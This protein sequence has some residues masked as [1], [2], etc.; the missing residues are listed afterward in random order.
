VKLKEREPDE[1]EDNKSVTASD[2]EGPA[3][4]EDGES[5]LEEDAAT[6]SKRC[7]Q[8]CGYKCI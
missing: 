4:G 3:D 6:A 5:E 7:P 1:G 2:D 8:L